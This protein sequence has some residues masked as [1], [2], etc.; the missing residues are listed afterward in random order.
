LY[1]WIA[2]KG[3]GSGLGCYKALAIRNEKEKIVEEGD[4]RKEAEEKK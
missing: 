1:D 4:S 2:H 3:S